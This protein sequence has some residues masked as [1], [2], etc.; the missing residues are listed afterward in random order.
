MITPLDTRGMTMR[1]ALGAAADRW[2]DSGLFC[3][4]PEAG[5]DWD[6][7]GRELSYGQ[8]RAEADRLAASLVRAGYGRGHRIAI[9]LENRPEHII[10]KF[11]ANAV[12]ASI[13]PMNPDLRPAEVA[14]IL[15]DSAPQLA[16]VAANRARAFAEANA[17]QRQ[18]T[19]RH[20]PTVAL[21]AVDPEALL[22]APNIPAQ[23]GPVVPTDEGS[24]IYTSGT[25]GR[26]KGCMLSQ[27]Y[28]LHVGRWY[29]EA[30]GMLGLT[31]GDRLYN[32][33]P[34]FHVNALVMSFFG[35]LHI[36]GC[37]IQPRRFTRAGWWA[38]IAGRRATIAHYLG[39]IIPVLLATEPSAAE[40]SHGL[41][42]VMGA[43]IEPSLHA[44]AQERFGVPLIEGWGMT[45]MCRAI[46]ADAEP[47][48]IDTR[49][50]GRPR[51]GLE[52]KVFDADDREAAYGEPGEMVLRH[53]AETPREGFFS[54]YL[55]KTD[56]TEEAWRSGWFH[57]GD[58]VTMDASGMIYFVD[59]KKNIIRRSGENIAAAEV[60]A[61]VM[62]HPAVAQVAVISALDPI[63]EEEVMACV[64]LKSGVAADAALARAIFDHVFS[65]LAYY[66]APGWL[67][68][69][70][71]LPVT[72]TQK[73]QKH[74][75]FPDGQD[76]TQGA[77]DFRPLKK[78][79]GA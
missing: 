39:V 40:R 78:R 67:L 77:F 41:R 75:M 37:Q 73:V 74:A 31:E 44:P 62:A 21:D 2:P 16:I 36:G 6:P 33:L 24:L 69:R 47:R 42:V 76:P 51:A 22:P 5:R 4:P 3:A 55:N 50:I 29:A 68:F 26:P 28:E 14:Y 19:R 64:V 71:D 23:K 12:G 15:T 61:C 66:K 59:R 79:D 10:W 32:P 53:S 46:V 65:S 70:D 9:D 34:L 11:A 25:T 43:G 13:V 18:G 48:M 54:G 7:E 72:G 60:E 20:I 52:A 58:T 8:I 17:I 57:T 63:R 56:A 27:G 35:M 45:E 30:S 38:D 49:A 1:D